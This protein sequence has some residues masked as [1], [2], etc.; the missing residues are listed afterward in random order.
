MVSALDRFYRRIY[1]LTEST[2]WLG[3]M[4]NRLCV[5]ALLRDNRRKSAIMSTR[6]I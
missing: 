5:V 2:N 4:A 1:A 3:L 6:P